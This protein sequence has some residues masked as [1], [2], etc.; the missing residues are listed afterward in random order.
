MPGV[1]LSSLRVTSDFDATAYTRGA[2]QKVDADARMI[3]SDKALNAALAQSDAALAKIP[4]G[5]ASVSKSLLDGYGAGQQFEALIRRI[6]NAAD[7][8]MGLDRV[9]LLLDAA[10]RKFGLTADA[11]NLAAT[12]YVSITA[13]VKELN[14]QYEI[15]NEVAARAAAAMAQVSTAAA[16]Q[17]SINARLGV[18]GGSGK[19]AQESAD[20][21]LAQFGGL[22]GIARAKAQEAGNAFAADLDARMVAG[23]GKSARDSANAFDAELS[24]LDEIAGMRAQQAGTNFQR[25]LT[26]AL[27]GGG[28][29]ATS[30][31]ATFSA[32]EEQFNRLEAIAAAK[33]T[34][35]AQATQQGL[36]DA[37]RMDTRATDY[38]LPDAFGK[39]NVATV[40]ALE[41]MAKAE[42]KAAAQAA[43]LRAEI[44]PLESRNGQTRQADGRVP[45]DARPGL[46]LEL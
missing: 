21:F 7:R 11:A 12:G 15:Q 24:R 36:R 9:N 43:A 45:E 42:E 32:L 8:G 10:Y 27:G 37:F 3:A 1:A 2:Q 39:T 20:A 26:E 4:G 18:G 44:N 35:I 23:A 34:Q 41:E 30:R 28:G 46:N 17:S 6:N 5:M 22:E 16:A 14:E 25:S 33:S 38:Q 29:S 13:A 19:S 40:S 31:G